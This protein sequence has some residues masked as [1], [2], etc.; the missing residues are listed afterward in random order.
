MDEV[1]RTKHAMSP[2][3]T[4]T[5]SSITQPTSVGLN[6]LYFKGVKGTAPTLSGRQGVKGIAPTLSDSL[7]GV[8]GIAPTLSEDLRYEGTGIAPVFSDEASATCSSSTSS[9][10]PAAPPEPVQYRHS[11]RGKSSNPVAPVRRH[12]LQHPFLQRPPSQYSADACIEG[13]PRVSNPV[14][15]ARRHPYRE[16]QRRRRTTT[17]WDPI[18]GGVARRGRRS[19]SSRGLDGQLTR[20]RISRALRLKIKKRRPEPRRLLAVTHAVSCTG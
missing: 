8:K 16:Q 5:N 7:K 11:C 6:G 19:S 17:C 18:P 4:L 12:P 3:T 1:G 10:P 2:R 13:S 20:G 15:P 14:A 9:V